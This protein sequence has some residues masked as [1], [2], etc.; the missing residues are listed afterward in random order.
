MT[1]EILA[2][3]IA[4]YLKK[5]GLLYRFDV[6]ADLRM[7]VGQAKKIKDKY[8]HDRGYPDLLILQKTKQFGGLFIELKKSEDEVF[9][10]S[11]DLRE[12]KHLEEQIEYHLKLREQGYYTTFCWSFEM[13]LEILMEYFDGKI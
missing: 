13:F 9:T 6:C 4:K 12:N 10:K 1:E 7:S 3:E 8:H 2:V 5:N 11:G